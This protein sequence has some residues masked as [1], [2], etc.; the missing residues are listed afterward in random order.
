VPAPA[1]ATPQAPLSAEQEKWL[2]DAFTANEDAARQCLAEAGLEAPVT[3]GIEVD[4]DGS[5]ANWGCK[6]AHVKATPTCKCMLGQFLD[7][8]YWPTSTGFTF[9]HIYY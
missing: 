3:V 1:P 4:P 8:S 2:R 5:L 6:E 9:S 7:W